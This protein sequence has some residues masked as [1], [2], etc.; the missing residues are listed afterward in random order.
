MSIA[1]AI[2][3]FAPA[4]CRQLAAR[5]A[6]WLPRCA[7]PLLLLFMCS[8]LPIVG[9]SGSPGR[10]DSAAESEPAARSEQPSPR[11]AQPAPPSAQQA[12]ADSASPAATA[13]TDNAATG[14]GAADGSGPMVDGST[15]GDSIAADNSSGASPSAVDMQLQEDLIRSVVDNFNRLDEFEPSEILPQLRDR[16][17]QW[18]W[19]SRRAINW[20]RDPLLTTLDAPLR[21][22]RWSIITSR[23]WKPA[24]SPSTT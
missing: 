24:C 20:Q 19:Q 11:I 23:T 5:G 6:A 21:T 3:N 7:R 4:G 22:R 12:T 13:A 8:L 17:N 9:C 16:L 1:T 15:V 10:P 2:S 18:M 14:A